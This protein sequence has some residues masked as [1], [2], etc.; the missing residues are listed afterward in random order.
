MPVAPGAES[1]T[2]KAGPEILLIASD[3]GQLAF[4]DDVVRGTSAVDK[5]NVAVIRQIVMSA[6]H[7]HQWRDAGTGGKEQILLS[8]KSGASELSC[9]PQYAHCVDGFQIVV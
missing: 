8:R 5:R 9:G 6:R 7:R 3:Q 4:K 2:N 1:F